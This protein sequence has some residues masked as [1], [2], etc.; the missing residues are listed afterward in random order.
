MS[1]ENKRVEYPDYVHCVLTGLYDI[2]ADAP[3]GPRAE[4]KTWCGREGAE[5]AH[6]W[7]FMDPTHAALNGKKGGRLV[8]C[9]ECAKAIAAAVSAGGEEAKRDA[10]V[11]RPEGDDEDDEDEEDELEA[12]ACE[13]GCEN[14]APAGK[15]FCSPA[16]EACENESKSVTGC[17]GIC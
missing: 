2:P 8:A 16:C 12:G 5:L 17:D 10:G 4:R 15:R 13:H 6:E 14:E 1:E 9:P 7:L 3:G 11:A